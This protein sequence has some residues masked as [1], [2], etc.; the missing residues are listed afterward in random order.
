LK[1]KKK[2]L[3]QKNQ[4]NNLESMYASNNFMSS[5]VDS[6]YFSTKKEVVEVRVLLQEAEQQ[7]NLC[8]Q[9]LKAEK[10]KVELQDMTIKELNERN[11]LTKQRWDKQVEQL[12]IQLQ[13]EVQMRKA[14]QENNEELEK[15]LVHLKNTFQTSKTR[16]ETDIPPWAPEFFQENCKSCDSEF[17][18]FTRRHHCRLCGFIFCSDC[19]SRRLK[20]PSKFYQGQEVR[21]C[22][23][24]FDSHILKTNLLK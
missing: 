21:V 17:S 1:N 12:Q 23:T 4:Q 9:K 2:E 6:M 16:E 24:C 14:F 5:T 11:D 8:K 19:S 10:E 13:N 20:N 15:E 7:I 22:S 18:F 3:D